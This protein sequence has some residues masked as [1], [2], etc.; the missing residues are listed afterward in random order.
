[1][2]HLLNNQVLVKHQSRKKCIMS[3][4]YVQIVPRPSFLLSFR[5]NT[6]TNAEAIGDL[7]DNSLEIDVNA[8]RVSITKSPNQIVIADNGCGMSLET[9]CDALILGPRHVPSETDLGLFGIGLKNAPISIGRK[10]TVITK[11]ASSNHVTAVYDLD[12]LLELNEFKL[13]IGE[14]TTKEVEW[15]NSFT[16]NS[17]TGTVIIIEELDRVT[18][19]SDKAFINDLKKY[20]G[21]V[22]RVFIK[23][24]KE[25]VVN[26]EKLE[27]RDLLKAY[28]TT[29]EE[30]EINDQIYE[31]ERPSGGKFNVRIRFGFFPRPLENEKNQHKLNIEN[32]GFYVMRNDRQLVRATWFKLFSKHNEFNRVRAE[33]FTSGAVD[34]VFLINYEKNTIDLRQWFKDSLR[35]KIGSV[36]TSYKERIKK[37]NIAI[38]QH[39][40]ENDETH[41]RIADEINS[42]ANRISQIRKKVDGSKVEDDGNQTETKTRSKKVDK[43]Q[44]IETKMKKELVHFATGKMEFS[45]IC[46]FE[47][48]GNGSLCIRWNVDH[49]FYLFYLSQTLEVQAGFAKLLFALG[50]SVVI[51]SAEEEEYAVRLCD[52]ELR[53][54]EEFRKLME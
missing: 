53:M 4:N 12:E 1:M 39:N 27:Y 3:K 25:I 5:H 15:F 7:V 29:Q 43:A 23:D 52:L 11:A 38:K 20:L 50:R 36:I 2:L 17:S 33:I 19:S 9:L 16:Q 21:E 47:D 14:S 34:D 31:F 51:L 49:P 28:Y 48:M 54:G 35:D 44:V 40:P 24:K 13:P 30:T 37:E 42:K 6:L 41:V 18:A 22:F 26:N 46:M 45:R 10:F 8:S 32:Q